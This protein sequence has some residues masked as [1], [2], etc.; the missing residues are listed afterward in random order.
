MGYKKYDKVAKSVIKTTV[1][2]GGKKGK[3]LVK[4][5]KAKGGKYLA[6]KP[7]GDVDVSKLVKG[8]M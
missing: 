6:K 4:A 2:K 1:K 8:A 5:P 3:Y 7:K